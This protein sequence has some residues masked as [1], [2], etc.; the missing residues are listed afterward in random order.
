MYAIYKEILG[1]PTDYRESYPVWH[2]DT[3]E[4]WATNTHFSFS[5]KKV[6]KKRKHKGGTF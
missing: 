4:A 2:G 6:V 3:Y 5:S 1:P